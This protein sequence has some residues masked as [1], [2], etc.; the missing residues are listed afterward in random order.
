LGLVHQKN[1]N[2]RRMRA[3]SRFAIFARHIEASRCQRT[4][5]DGESPIV[6]RHLPVDFR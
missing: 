5:P 2:A 3:A 4:P 1:L 6:C